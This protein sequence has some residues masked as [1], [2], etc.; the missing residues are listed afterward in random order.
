MIRL[1]C[2]AQTYH[3]GKT[4]LDTLVG[5]A[6][7]ASVPSLPESAELYEAAD[8]EHYAEL[9]IGDHPSGPAEILVNHEDA[10]MA[11]IIADEGFLKHYHH[12]DIEISHLFKLN[13]GRFLG[14][15]YIE[16]FG[17]KN[18]KL[19]NSMAFLFKLL[20]VEKALSIQA[21]PHKSL[22]EQLHKEHPEIYK[23]DNH[24]PEIA[25]ALGDDFMA[26]FGFLSPEKLALNFKQNK[27]LSEVFS[28]T[29]ST[30]IDADFLK[31]CVKHMF[32]ELDKDLEN[33]QGITTVLQHEITAIPESDRSLHQSLFL[34]LL[35]QYGPQDI[36][37]IFSF[38]FNIFNLKRDEAVVITPNEPH[39]Y[40]RGD[41]VECMANSDNVVR[42]GLTP[43]LKDKETLYHMLPYDTLTV[44][45]APV[46][47]VPLFESAGG[48]SVVEY[49]TGFE[50][51]RVIK[52]QASKG[53]E[54]VRVRYNTFSMVIV[55]GGKG[56][57]E[58]KEYGM[59]TIEA[60]QAY[61]VMPEQEF[62]VKAEQDEPLVMFIANCDI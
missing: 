59:F 30:V 52:V 48:S 50:E 24:K 47:G 7:L 13:P 49:K 45:R 62:A 16:H 41:L 27:A 5:K 18:P 22:A 26:L 8:Q 4:G 3:W 19:Q 51:F 56:T 39:A 36:G 23:D 10:Q 60:Y 57:V 11:S 37:L 35:S 14:H 44:E 6:Y 29:E 58:F 21:H 20:A 17:Q 40:I 1:H 31:G 43:K 9:W 46:R 61:Y 38:F 53:D 15:K 32:Y 42:G 2:K 12:K 28:Y 25:I 34:T 33:L 54:G 55:I